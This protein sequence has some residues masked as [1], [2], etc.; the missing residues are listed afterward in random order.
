MRI[1]GSEMSEPTYVNVKGI[2]YV[3]PDTV[4]KELDVAVAAAE[5][6]TV[7]IAKV[8]TAIK[9]DS[10]TNEDPTSHQWRDV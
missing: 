3:H 6:R 9:G 10:D 5:Q 7:V 4:R 2:Y 8:I 1:G